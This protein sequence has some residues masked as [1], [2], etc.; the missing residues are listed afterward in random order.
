MSRCAE[1]RSDWSDGGGMEESWKT[2][3]V[4]R[5]HAGVSVVGMVCEERF[6]RFRYRNSFST[7]LFHFM[8]VYLLAK[9]PRMYQR[10]GRFIDQRPSGLSWLT[11]CQSESIS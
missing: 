10:Q 3:D 6:S 4:K 9:K 5:R 7:C 1:A 11:F 8:F 2:G